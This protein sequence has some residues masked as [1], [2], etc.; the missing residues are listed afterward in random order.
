LSLGFY[1]AYRPLP[2]P[3]CAKRTAQRTTL[4]LVAVLSV[5]VA[6]YPALAA[7]ITAGRDSNSRVDARGA[8]AV[9]DVKGMTCEG[10]AAEIRRELQAVPGV[11]RVDVSFEHRRA[12]VRWARPGADLTPLIAA[13]E[14]AGYHASVAQAETRR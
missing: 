11:T 14:K 6:T 3:A 5:C 1:F 4:W 7:R 13:V 9:L 8:L 2:G 10:C 12:E